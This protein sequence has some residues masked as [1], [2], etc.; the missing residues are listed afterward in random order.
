MMRPRFSIVRDALA[1]MNRKLIALQIALAL[2]VFVLLVLWLRLPDSSALSLVATV[3]VGVLLLGVAGGGEAAL[4]L[5]VYGRPVRIGRVIRGAVLLLIA[6]ALWLGWGALL[7]HFRVS[8][9]TVAGYWNSRFPASARNVFSYAHIYQWLEWMWTALAWIGAGVAA[10]VVFSM[11]VSERPARAIRA[12]LLSATFWLTLVCVGL[13]VSLTAMV[14]QW[15]PGHGLVIETISLIVRLSCAV[16][17]DAVLLVAGIAV[18]A[19]CNRRGNTLYEMP[20]GSADE[21]QPRTDDM[22]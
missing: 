8:D 9:S 20:A 14:T 12:T 19:A 22:P 18:I 3:L 1:L 6:M 10:V 11:T 4:L 5:R 15:T 13:C 16:V 7:E 17:V 2:T 21:S